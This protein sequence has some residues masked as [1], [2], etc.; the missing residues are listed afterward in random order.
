M[1]KLVVL[2]VIVLFSICLNMQSA[3]ACSITAAGSC[4]GSACSDG[5][6]CKKVSDIECKC[7]KTRVD[8]SDVIQRK[9]SDEAGKGAAIRTGCCYKKEENTCICAV[10]VLEEDCKSGYTWKEG[11]NCYESDKTGC[12]D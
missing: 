6:E 10:P 12:C 5:N 8:S 1:K 3:R 7:V 9:Q 2:S 11:K 4:G